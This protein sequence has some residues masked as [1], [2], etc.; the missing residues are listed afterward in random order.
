MSE[1]GELYKR[2]GKAI[3]PTA[4]MHRPVGYNKVMEILDSASKEYPTYEQAKLEL[5]KRVG[6]WE[7]G[8]GKA[9]VHQILTELRDTWQEMV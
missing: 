5:E 4:N 3:Y 8:L 9:A 6:E 2:I 1:Q 7:D